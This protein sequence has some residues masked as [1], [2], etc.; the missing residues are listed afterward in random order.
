MDYSVVVATRNRADA[1]KLSLPLLVGQT[2]PPLEIIVVDSSDAPEAIRDVVAAVAVTTDIPLHYV[3]SAPGASLQRNIGADRARGAVTLF[4]DDDSL[5]FPDTMARIMAIYER[6]AEGLVGGVCGTEVARPPCAIAG[7]AAAS[8]ERETKAGGAGV[9]Y[10]RRRKLKARF[11][12]DPFGNLAERKYARL[13]TPDWLDEEEA[14][15]VHHMTG[16]RMSFRTEVIRRLRFDEGLGRYALFEDVDASLRTLDSHCLVAA[17]GAR[18]Y[19]HK[20]PGR[21]DAERTLGA[22]HI[23][24]RG[25]ILSK[26]QPLDRRLRS[27]AYLFSFYKVVGY[28]MGLSSRFG[29]DRLVSALAACRALPELFRAPPDRL[30]SVYRGLRERC[31]GA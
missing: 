17:T 28:G 3:H 5:L 11:V 14:L 29:R 16:F 10:R 27:E 23:L 31:L 22:M 1:L 2:R 30:E 13:R 7:A 8:Y 21:R 20:A 12:A 6:D 25:Y 15:L 24:N 18:V 26:H 19:H 9:S 4:P